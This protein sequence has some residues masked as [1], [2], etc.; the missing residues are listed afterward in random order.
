MFYFLWI[1]WKHYYIS[2]SNKLFIQS[3]FNYSFADN[4]NDCF[5]WKIRLA[6]ITCYTLEVRARTDKTGREKSNIGLRSQLRMTCM[7][8]PRTILSNMGSSITV[9]VV[10]K[11]L[12]MKSTPKKEPRRP[13][14]SIT[15]E[16]NY[17]YFNNKNHIIL[18][19]I[20]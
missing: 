1:I 19:N 16:V 9:S 20:I 6:D 13:E 12:P 11:T 2:Y 10:T 14:V 15:E 7:A 3:F 4:E 17:S 8:F 18:D 5:P